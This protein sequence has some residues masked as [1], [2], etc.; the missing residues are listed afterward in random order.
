MSWSLL[1][2]SPALAA[3][4]IVRTF[5]YTG[6]VQTFTVPGG[7]DALTFTVRG[8]RGGSGWAG[9]STAGAGGAGEQVTATV[10]GLENQGAPMQP[11]ETLDLIVGG[12][13]GN[14]TAPSNGCAGNAFYSQSQGGNYSD[15]VTDGAAIWNFVGGEGG[16]GDLCGGGGGGGGG[17]DT[18]VWGNGYGETEYFV[19]GGGGGGGGGGG[20]AGYGGGAGGSA[21]PGAGGS[22][23]GHGSGVAGPSSSSQGGNGSGADDA[24][25]AGGGGAGGAG[26]PNGGLGGSGGSAGAGGGGG[27][28][29]GESFVLGGVTNN[30]VT[31]AGPAGAE[32]IVS[33]SYTP[34]T[35]LRAPVR[36]LLKRCRKSAPHTKQRCMTRR[37]S[38]TLIFR[39]TSGDRLKL[40]R[41]GHVY[42]TG[43]FRHGRIELIATRPVPKGRYTLTATNPRD[44]FSII[45]RQRIKIP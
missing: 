35:Q 32:G 12:D 9:G 25:S 5:S 11:G 13:G 33:I 30:A 34:T 42:A 36:L 2:S 14:A 22:G 26:Y 7:V 21:G 4:L 1:A 27:G 18:I 38:A 31:G 39:V 28:G 8:G 15:F 19:A 29:S 16:D 3:S 6:H 45:R 44:R 20:I 40:I 43:R 24:S 23:L 17:A 41:A 10:R 37:I